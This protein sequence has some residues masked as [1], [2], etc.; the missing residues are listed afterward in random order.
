MRSTVTGRS[1]RRSGALV[2]GLWLAVP[3]AAD[4]A[5]CTWTGLG[6]S[7]VWSAAANWDGCGGAHPTPQA[8][9]SLMFPGGASRAGAV[10]D[11]LN[12]SVMSVRVT[13]VPGTASRYVIS[14][15]AI[16]LT[17]GELQFAAAPDGA[18]Q[19][20][21][22]DAPVTLG[23]AA[24]ISNTGT[25][26]AR[27]GA[28]DVNG[29]GLLFSPTSANLEVAGTIGGA[30]PITNN[31]PRTL[32]LHGANTFTGPLQIDGGTVLIDNNAALGSASVGT[33]V[34]AGAR[35]ML[36]FVQIM[37][38]LTL[39]G[40][41]IAATGVTDAYPSSSIVADIALTADSFFDA[42]GLGG[43]G[44]SPSTL[45][46]QGALS[47]SAR[48]TTRGAIAVFT[49]SPAFTG[50][51]TVEGSLNFTLPAAGFPNSAITSL[52]DILGQGTIGSIT[53]PAGYVSPN[54]EG[55]RT[56]NVV[57]GLNATLS[58]RLLSWLDTGASLRVT[59]T[60]N[61]GNAR[62]GFS[63]FYA[64]ANIVLIDNDGT[65]PVVG[66][67]AGLPEGS[68]I[69]GYTRYIS[70]EGGTGNDVTLS[71]IAP[72]QPLPPPPPP[73]YTMVSLRNAS[74]ITDPV[75][76]S[77]TVAS[78]AATGTVTFTR[79][80]VIMPGCEARP[81]SRRTA[82]ATCTH[83]FERTGEFTIVATY[84]GD[85]AH[86]AWTSPPLIQVVLDTPSTV[87]YFAEG[88]INFFKTTIGVVNRRRSVPASTCCFERSAD[89]SNRDGW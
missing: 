71:P 13:G 62:L 46:F 89:L 10:N 31:A 24:T 50:P 47:G 56:G 44:E 37:E 12:L 25:A 5:T 58:P 41:V 84:G 33:T 49:P 11:L 70:Y 7:N 35:L 23:A 32:M 29:F 65:D 26:P 85:G 1:A 74:V 16:V 9:D 3:A 48:L 69:Y 14:G 82:T 22:F 72:P 42:T 21:A 63:D 53:A 77:A 80:G 51:T 43:P 64:P 28:I 55:L 59:G 76:F 60:V 87:Q 75:V 34:A 61:L 88:E 38:P 83:S 39:S 18:G 27:L 67:F 79:D 36:R 57:L 86:P 52:G 4:A 30:G 54:G 2:L 73:P 20:P 15:N 8:G 40:G 19:G 17:G 45:G 78:D 68:P 6:A 81:L 66:D